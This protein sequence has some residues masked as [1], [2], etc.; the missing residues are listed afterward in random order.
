MT[1][2]LIPDD[3]R[4]FVLRH[5]DSIAQLEAL[6]LLLRANPGEAWGIGK[7]AKR[8]YAGEAE[9]A[10]AVAA[11]CEDGFVSVAGGVFHYSASPEQR[12]MV[13]RLADIYSRH[14]IPVTI[15]GLCALAALLCTVLLFLAYRRSGY[16]LLFWSGLCFAGLTVNNLLLVADKL[17]FPASDLSPWRTSVALAAMIVLLYGLIWRAE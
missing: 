13:D 9:I 12:Q 5:I 8:L 14:L 6:L 1:N 3:V 11:L 16:G 2:D 10:A 17:I 15:Y 4:D 7:I